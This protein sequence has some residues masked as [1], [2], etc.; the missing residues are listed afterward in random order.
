V[1]YFLLLAI[2]GIACGSETTSDPLRD[3]IVR[4]S[5]LGAVLQAK[6]WEKFD[7]VPSRKM[8]LWRKEG[9]GVFYAVELRYMSGEEQNHITLLDTFP[10]YLYYHRLVDFEP[11]QLTGYGSNEM[12][13]RFGGSWGMGS[14]PGVAREEDLECFFVVDLKNSKLLWRGAYL[15]HY[16]QM[17]EKNVPD[18]LFGP[19]KVGYDYKV[20]IKNGEI[21]IDSLHYFGDSVDGPPDH[22]PGRYQ[23]KKGEFALV[24]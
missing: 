16:E 15:Y 12:I 4:D 7:S 9:E 17:V 11:A 3:S 24:K 14:Q 19:F 2:L 10:S 22:L 23:W 18:S 21:I 5:V 13:I 1:R 8:E 6:G 20:H